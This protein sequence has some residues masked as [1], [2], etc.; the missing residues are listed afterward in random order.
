MST[1]TLSA[2]GST[3]A[4]DTVSGTP[5]RRHR[6]TGIA[7]LATLMLLTGVA[8][9]PARAERRVDRPERTT[10]PATRTPQ[11]C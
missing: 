11:H 8:L 6:A 3:P 4:I 10:A 7:I 1:F 5:A 9:I 2:P